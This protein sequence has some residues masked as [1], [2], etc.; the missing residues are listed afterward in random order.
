MRSFFAAAG[1]LTQLPVPGSSTPGSLA[2]APGYFPAVGFLIGILLA[3]L[4]AALQPWLPPAVLAAIVILTLLA[5]TGGLH[6]DGLADTCDGFFATAPS[7]LRR[8][9]IMRDSRV[10]GFGVAGVT[11]VLLLQYAALSSLPAR[12]WP[13][14]LLLMGV[15]SRWAVALVLLTFPYGRGQGMGLAFK[16]GHLVPSVLGGTLFALGASLLVAG[17]FGGLA[18]LA[19]AVVSLLAARLLLMRL[20]G[21]TGDS[22]GAINEV[23]QAL[24]LVVAAA[25][26]HVA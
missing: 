3:A 5:V 23:S 24:V 17:P 25:A 13:P 22:Y 1:F 12:A 2:A 11:S 10:G 20:P 14:A 19:T 21:L 9:E 6:I 18:M 15:Q 4:T 26:A 16:Q 7:P 8:L